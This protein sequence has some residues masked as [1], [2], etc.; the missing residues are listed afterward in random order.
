MRALRA[1]PSPIASSVDRV[2]TGT[3]PVLQTTVAAVASWYLAVLV[4]PVERPYFAPIAA[5]VA[6]GA[7]YAERG[8]RARDL[9]LG[10]VVGVAVALLLL[11]VLGTGPLQLGLL[12][13]L[14]MVAALVLG[15]GPVLV[16]QAAISA[17]LLAVLESGTDTP[18]VAR[19][20]EAVIGGGVALAVNAVLFPP[21]PL[22][23]VDRA[24]QPLIEQLARVLERTADALESGSV[25]EARRVLASAREIDERVDDLEEALEVGRETARSSLQRRPAL[26]RM[27]GYERELRQLD[28][29]VRDTRV[30]ARD[31]VRFVRWGG[32]APEELPDAIRRLAAAVRTL[33]TDGN[34]RP[35]PEP[36]RVLAF[37]AAQRA[38]AVLSRRTD[39]ATSA[40]VSQIRHT[41]VDLVRAARSESGAPED[42]YEAPT[43]EVLAPPPGGPGSAER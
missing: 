32:S 2:R 13:L 29:A 9:V 7:S 30:L 21:N 39:L 37:E 1:R 11:A 8:R 23:M 28:F 27:R 16:N 10:V 26:G 42:S 5:I 35:A 34:E 14:A 3:W 33:A 4:L 18:P 25:E 36:T 20:A 12:I 22:T 17:I 43:E 31:V 15:G 41:A 19:L 24:V 40:I 38:S 6:L